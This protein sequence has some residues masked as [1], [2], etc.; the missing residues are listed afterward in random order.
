LQNR[1]FRELWANP[2]NPHPG[3]LLTDVYAREVYQYLKT[4]YLPSQ[5]DV[6]QGSQ[7]RQPGMSLIVDKSF[8]LAGG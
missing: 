3:A 2:A 4:T 7:P 6:I 5:A 1:K 8:S